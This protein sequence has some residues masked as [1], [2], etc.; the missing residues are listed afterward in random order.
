M[1]ET[2]ATG[3]T[4]YHGYVWFGSMV[5]VEDDKDLAALEKLPEVESIWRSAPKPNYPWNQ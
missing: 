1:D 2:S 5:T 3:N 4:Y